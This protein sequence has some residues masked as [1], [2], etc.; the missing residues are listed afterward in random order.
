[1][2]CNIGIDK[3]AAKVRRAELYYLRALSRSCRP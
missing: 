3:Y 2:N 1:M